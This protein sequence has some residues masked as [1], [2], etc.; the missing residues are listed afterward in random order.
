LSVGGQQRRVHVQDQPS[1]I[2]EVR[3][4]ASDPHPSTSIGTGSPE[5][6]ELG[7]PDPVQH[8]VGPRVRGDRTEQSCLVPQP[9]EVSEAV[10]AVGE[11]DRKFGEHPA[12]QVHRRPL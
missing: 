12:R 8:P 5:Q 1:G 2:G 9:G 7:S 11:G 4:A 3:S 6:L 10:P